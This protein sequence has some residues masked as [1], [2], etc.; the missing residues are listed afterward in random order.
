MITACQRLERRQHIGSSD[1]AAIVGVDPWR[2]AGDVYW[3]KLAET[4][5]RPNSAMQIGN[6][7]EPVLLDL[8]E[9]R[10]GPIERSPLFVDD[11]FSILAANL[12]GICLREEAVIEAKYVGPR[13]ADFWGEPE[14]DQ[15]PDHVAIQVQH[16][17]R[18]C[19]AKV[20]YIPAA[21]VRPM[22]GLQFE[23]FRVSRDEELIDSLVDACLA[24]WKHH[25]EPHVPPPNCPPSSEIL[26]RIRRE[27]GSLVDL[28]DEVAATLLNMDS[29]KSERKGLDE[30]ID[31][32]QA[33][34]LAAL[35]ESEAGRLPDGRLVCYCEENAGDKFD[36]KALK[37]ANP[38]IYGL[39]A[40]PST[41]R[42]LRIK[43]GKK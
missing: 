12:D 30:E 40:T 26:K 18:C 3:S 32:C 37:A 36:A 4:E 38:D 21:I 29:L 27:P 42:V 41:R 11:E 2:N 35:G 28:G 39:F 17:M 22:S 31:A 13:S 6:R 10:F 14:T 20:A 25:V 19:G 9:E 24:F 33:A 16:Q 23:F 15:V 1:A 34:V 5:D 8:A 7:M 43:K